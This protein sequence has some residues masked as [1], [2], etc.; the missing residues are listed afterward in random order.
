M[1]LTFVVPDLHG[2]SDLLE[3]ALAA[4]LARCA[5]GTL[6][7]L[8]DYVD[9]GPDSRGIITRLRQG[10]PAGWI[11]VP[12]KGNHDAMMVTALRDPARMAWWLER[13]GDIAVTSYGGDA[14]AIPEADIAWLDGLALW[15][16]DAH[17]IYV[18]AGLEPGIALDAQTERTLLWKRYPQGDASGFDGRHVVHGHNACAEGPELLE[19]RTNLDTQAWRTGRLVIGVFEDGQPGGPVDFIV[20]RG[21][22]LAR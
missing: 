5:G 13:G 9:K 16:A 18:H 4:I 20:V 19:G 2:R 14:S 1:S 12:L 22:A 10:L 8:G 17:R 21:P 7:I 11:L 15:H 3:Q 6:V